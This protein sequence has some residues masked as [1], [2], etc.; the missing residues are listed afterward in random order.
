MDK[1][2]YKEETI[3]IG[4]PQR[5][6]FFAP[7]GSPEREI[8]K[9]DVKHNPVLD[10]VINQQDLI[11]SCLEDVDVYTNIEKYQSIGGYADYLNTQPR[12]GVYSDTSDLPKDVY[13]FYETI[14][15]LAKQF[16]DI[17]AQIKNL[18]SNKTT[19]TIGTDSAESEIK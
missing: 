15:A 14:D 16:Y 19:E 3:V 2:Q 13:A 9:L 7:S 18:E 1:V 10:K 6:R 12:Q 4:E 17:E 11:N 5:K 8:Y